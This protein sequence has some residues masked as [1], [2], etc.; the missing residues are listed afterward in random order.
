MEVA[1]RAGLRGESVRGW[2]SVGRS[3]LTH[4]MT[5]LTYLLT[6]PLTYLLTY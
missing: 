6:H 5:Y 3:L 1:V 2:E 4:S